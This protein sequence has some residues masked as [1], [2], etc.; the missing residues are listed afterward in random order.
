MRRH[1]RSGLHRHPEVEIRIGV[2]KFSDPLPVGG[3]EVVDGKISRSDG[4]IE[5]GFGV[6]TELAVDQPTG[7]SNYQR[8]RHEW[9]RVA[10]KNRPASLVVGVCIVS[11]REDNAGVDEKASATKPLG[12][13]VLILGCP[14]LAR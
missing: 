14:S 9:S 5:V 2:D 7:L 12:K 11:G 10:L 13:H 8:C 6:G 3:V 1:G 4:P